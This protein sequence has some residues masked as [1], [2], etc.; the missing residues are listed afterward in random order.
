MLTVQLRVVAKLYLRWQ[1]FF[2]HDGVLLHLVMT[3]QTLVQM[4]ATI[5][6]DT[7]GGGRPSFRMDEDVTGRVIL[8]SAQ[9]IGG[10]KAGVLCPLQ[11]DVSIE[12][13]LSIEGMEYSQTYIP[14]SMIV[15]E[16]HPTDSSI[17]LLRSTTTIFQGT[18]A[19][20]AD[21]KHEFPF[22]ISLPRESSL[23]EVPL[24][25]SGVYDFTGGLPYAI[26]TVEYRVAFSVSMSGC[27]LSIPSDEELPTFHLEVPRVA[28]AILQMPA[29]E[30]KERK[31][32]RTKFRLRGEVDGS[33]L[34]ERLK[35]VYRPHE[36][37]T[38][39]LWHS[40]TY[41]RY[42]YPGQVLELR[43]SVWLDDSSAQPMF[44]PDATLVS[45]KA[46]LIANTEVHAG[47]KRH[48]I[49]TVQQWST[50]PSPPT[51]FSDGPTRSLVIKL[52]DPVENH[53]CSFEHSELR[54]HYS[55]R[56]AMQLC[57]A[58]QYLYMIRTCDVI[59]A[60]APLQN[61]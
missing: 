14:P 17:N 16:F 25:P 47:P 34:K 11:I 2:S 59:V 23:L 18:M 48:D 53:G 1:L 57:I 24:P 36:H 35:A 29:S 31:K 44:L 26:V 9:G 22:A 60:P 3:A 45:F 27:N 6:L 55:L 40:C 49:R 10:P 46:D 32:L 19:T 8:S 39:D 61:T 56:V 20:D 33:W 52:A 37:L 21:T 38:L 51:S 42:L 12:G 30:F 43:A 58:E 54:R 4:Q 7:C 28:E 50:R 15:P 13:T 5:L 41:S